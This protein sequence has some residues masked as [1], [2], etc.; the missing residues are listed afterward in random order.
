MNEE[1]TYKDV[2]FEIFGFSTTQLEWIIDV[3]YVYDHT[4]ILER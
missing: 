1:K 3:F 4:H 2:T